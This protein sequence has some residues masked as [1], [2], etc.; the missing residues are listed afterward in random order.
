MLS[1]I[2][3]LGNVQRGLLNA[4]MLEACQRV[5][6]APTTQP[7]HGQRDLNLEKDV[8]PM[9]CTQYGEWYCDIPT[10]TIYICNRASVSL[11]VWEF[12]SACPMNTFCNKIVDTVICQIDKPIIEPNPDAG[13]EVFVSPFSTNETVYGVG[14]P[15]AITWQPF[16]TNHSADIVAVRLD[17]GIGHG[18]V[19]IPILQINTVPIF[20]PGVTCYEWTPALTLNTSIIYAIQFSGLDSHNRVL[21]TAYATWFHIGS[22][23]LGVSPSLCHSNH[24]TSEMTVG[25]SC[26]SGSWA[27][28]GA[29]LYM[30]GQGYSGTFLKWLF[31][32]TCPQK[33]VCTVKGLD[34]AVGCEAPSIWL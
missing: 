32:S 23:G 27:C 14:V 4:L 24:S 2:K 10:N 29:N 1:N 18:N 15:N 9:A 13:F 19:V 5:L 11:L 16:A 6:S 30:C 12:F 7:N 8:N 17:L 20:Y 34:G 33:L 25:D 21:E 28:D 26:K 22:P 31:H 3:T